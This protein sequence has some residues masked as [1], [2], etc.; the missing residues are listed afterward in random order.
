MKGKYCLGKLMDIENLSDLKGLYLVLI[1]A[2]KIPPHLGLINNQR[3][4]S[5]ATSGVNIGD[6]VESLYRLVTNKSIATVFIKIDESSSDFNLE[7][8]LKGYFGQYESATENVTCLEPIKAFFEECFSLPVGN[9]KYVFNLIPLLKNN[10]LVEGFFGIHV[11][12]HLVKGK[13]FLNTYEM[14]DIIDRINALK[15]NA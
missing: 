11:K 4:Y 6:S 15:N 2:D 14:S 13:F 7:Q 3:Y 10:R 5:L 1:N 9:V 8:K 12:D